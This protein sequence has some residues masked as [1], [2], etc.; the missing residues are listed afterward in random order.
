MNRFLTLFL[1]TAFSSGMATESPINPITEALP[2]SFEISINKST[3]A[4]ENLIA[5]T[6]QNLQEQLALTDLILQ[7]RKE[8]ALFLENT[9]NKEQLFKAAKLAKSILVTIKDEQLLQV[10]DVDFV[11]ELTLFA[12][13]AKPSTS[14]S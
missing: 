6:R 3:E 10:F 7:Y 11:S 5:V 12:K 2:K 4:L 14:Q 9:D 8:Q 13:F 1:V